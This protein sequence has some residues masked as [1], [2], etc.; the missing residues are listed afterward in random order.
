MKVV[1]KIFYW[2]FACCLPVLLVTSTIAWEV[3]EIRL[4]EYGFNK[5]GI[6]QATG[7]DNQQLRAVAQRLIDYFDLR[8]DTA[9]IEV[10]RAGQKFDLFNERELIHLQDVRDLIRRDYRVQIVDFLFMVICTVVLMVG[11]KSGWR[12]PVRGLFWGSVITLGLMTILAVWAI[13]GFERFFILFHLISFS[14][15]YWLLDPAH[16]YLIRM[17][18]EGFFFDAAMLGYGAVILEALLIGGITWGIPKLMLR[19]NRKDLRTR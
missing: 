17:F 2:I 14:N 6:S 13:F 12:M 8:A 15:Q 11:L 19:E 18:P 16:D 10:N 1:Q 4:Y 3:N 9:Q 7:L 5:Y